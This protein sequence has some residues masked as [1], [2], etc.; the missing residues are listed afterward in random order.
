[1]ILAFIVR[2][3]KFFDFVNGYILRL[4]GWLSLGLL[5]V[6]TAIV[7]SGV[8]YR[9]VLDD[10]LVWAEEISKFLMVWMTFM[11]APLAFRGGALVAID[12]LPRAL[13]GW[14][15]AV[16]QIFIQLSIISLMVAFVDRG[17]FLA[18]NAFIQRA[19]T[20]DVSITY[21]YIAMP[22]GAFFMLLLSVQLL[23][24]AVRRLLGGDDDAVVDDDDDMPA[25]EVQGG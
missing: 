20:I 12:A 18:Q 14:A 13:S 5:G 10:A 16:L 6:M 7:F 22:I 4:C 11:A 2:I 9:Y 17:G 25:T 1:M 3:E 8:F 21:V 23:L 15:R 24:G 19:S